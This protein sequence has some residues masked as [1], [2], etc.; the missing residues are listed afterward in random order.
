MLELGSLRL[1][2][3]DDEVSEGNDSWPGLDGS[4]SG[5]ESE[6]SSAD[7]Y[8]EEEVVSS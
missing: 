3:E 2:P 6:L 4:R 5:S 8:S 1:D 7:E